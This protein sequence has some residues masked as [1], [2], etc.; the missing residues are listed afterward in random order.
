MTSSGGLPLSSSRSR[1][2]DVKAPSRKKSKDHVSISYPI[3]KELQQ[4]MRQHLGDGPMRFGPAVVPTEMNVRQQ[5]VQ[6]QSLQLTT[7]VGLRTLSDVKK[8]YRQATDE[9]VLRIVQFCNYHDAM[10]YDLLKKCKPHYFHLT[11]MDR[12]R[13][14][15]EHRLVVP[16]PHLA[17]RQRPHSRVVYFRPSRFSP[18]HDS[19]TSVIDSLIYVLD[20]WTRNDAIVWSKHNF[21][22]IPVTYCL[23][24]HLQEFESSNY[25]K[26]YWSKFMALLQGR[27]FPVRIGMVLWVDAPPC[28]DKVWTS[29]KYSM[30][31][32]QDFAKKNFRISRQELWKH[33][34]TD[35]EQWLPSD[36]FPDMN[37][38]SS[39][40]LRDMAHDYLQFQRFLETLEGRS[41]N[42]ETLA[43]KRRS[44]RR[45]IHIPLRKKRRPKKKKGEGLSAVDESESQ[46]APDESES[47][48]MDESDSHHHDYDDVSAPDSDD[49]DKAA[50]ED[51][52]IDQSTNGND[53]MSERS[54]SKRSGRI[55]RGL[56]KLKLRRK[57]TGGSSNEQ[58]PSSRNDTS[59]GNKP[60]LSPRRK[61]RHS[62][63]GLTKEKP[64][65]PHPRRSSL[66]ILEDMK[67]HMPQENGHIDSE[68]EPIIHRKPRRPSVFG[69]TKDPTEES[70][71]STHSSQR[72]PRRS[73]L[74]G[75]MKEPETNGTEHVIH[76]KPR[77]SSLFG[78][79]QEPTEQ[80]NGGAPTFHR[81]TRRSSLFGGAKDQSD[82]TDTV[83]SAQVVH[84]KPRRSSLL[85]GM[86]QSSVETNG[87]EQLNHRKPRRSSLFGGMKEE[88]GGA[89]VVP[90]RNRRA[91]L[92][93]L[94]E[95]KHHPADDTA[96][97]MADVSVDH[98]SETTSIRDQQIS[99]SPRRPRRRMSLT[100]I[101]APLKNRR[102]HGGSKG[103]QD[104]EDASMISDSIRSNDLDQSFSIS[105]L[106]ESHKRG[107]RRQPLPLSSSTGSGG[108]QQQGSE[109]TNN[110]ED[111]QNSSNS[112]NWD[113]I[114]ADMHR[115]SVRGM[116]NASPNPHS[117]TPT[118]P[119]NKTARRFSTATLPIDSP[120]L[121]STEEE[122]VEK[123]HPPKLSYFLEQV[124]RQKE[125]TKQLQ[126]QRETGN[127]TIS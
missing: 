20:N 108:S 11:S 61:A 123:K 69:G 121:T 13:D 92:T 86:K 50:D 71:G 53:S 67:E 44:G 52:D 47:R 54:S 38:D 114:L 15:E 46:N 65:F 19:K 73:S 68:I 40:T 76:R 112:Q 115:N 25:S 96:E 89:P 77:R 120:P 101:L 70:Q 41:Y 48:H 109:S 74:F 105:P 117:R 60:P 55:R 30:M 45:R 110:F 118:N 10:A 32:S 1:S 87:G 29:M 22:A 124:E 17:L 63:A 122:P 2:S 39:L 33:L 62:V 21:L 119:T 57:N 116:W 27:V 82:D 80:T 104:L 103:G 99:K 5:L 126:V 79:I 18:R 98:A 35:F 34:Q 125:R 83:G 95:I 36:E 26:D 6:G 23:L 4:K 94:G 102:N 84:R 51:D 100:G 81:K 64:M 91:S 59:R 9:Q 72:K 56:I 75:G 93:M 31:L 66:S 58:A 42:H 43:S 12:Q 16:I 3:D 14:I 113:Q 107:G 8:K 106:V 7:Y 49:E 97:N 37:R 111:S 24:V 127:A 78:G 28:F 88:N 90:H 85:G